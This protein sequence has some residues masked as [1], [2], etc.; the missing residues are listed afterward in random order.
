MKTYQRLAILAAAALLP[1]AA[2]QADPNTYPFPSRENYCP[3]GLQ[4]VYYDGAVS[5]SIPNQTESYF[6]V[7]RENAYGARSY[8]ASSGAICPE[9]VKG[10]YT[11]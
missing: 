7:M 4:P 6:S 5:C 11:E 9:G 3:A 2:A 8:R 1:A 10:C